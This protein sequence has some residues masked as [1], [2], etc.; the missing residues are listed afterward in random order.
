MEPQRVSARI[1]LLPDELFQPEEYFGDFNWVAARN[2]VKFSLSNRR[3]YLN[4]R[5]YNAFQRFLALPK[6]QAK[7]TRVWRWYVTTGGH[8][9][10]DPNKHYEQGLSGGR[11][12]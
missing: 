9:P 4:P 7:E 8:P 12:G 10:F 2:C 3:M 1:R 6:D 5:K 11:R